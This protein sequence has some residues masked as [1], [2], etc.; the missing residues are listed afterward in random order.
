MCRTTHRLTCEDLRRLD[1]WSL[2]RD[3]LLTGQGSI[4]WRRGGRITSQ[5]AIRADGKGGIILSHLSGEEPISGRV[6]LTSTRGNS[7]GYRHWF[8]CPGC[9][10]RVGVLYGA[11]WF[12]CRHCHDLRYE[13]Q[14]CNHTYSAISRV[15][16]IRMRLGGSADLSEPTPQRPRYMHHRTYDRLL[17]QQA[18]ALRSCSRSVS[19][20]CLK[21]GNKSDVN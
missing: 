11:I 21:I 9:H 12:R 18:M 20:W 10:R 14:R 6:P 19:N 3:G 5:I 16:K 17:H 8:L 13:S 4:T 7:G 15:Q 1:V 2:A